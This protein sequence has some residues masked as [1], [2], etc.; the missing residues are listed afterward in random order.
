M[1]S[2]S[3][4]LNDSFERLLI[5]SEPEQADDED[6]SLGTGAK[7]NKTKRAKQVNTRCSQCQTHFCLECF[8]SLHKRCK[9]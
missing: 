5:S 6:D 8:N 3:D 9:Q 7:Q 2:E 1:E 4:E